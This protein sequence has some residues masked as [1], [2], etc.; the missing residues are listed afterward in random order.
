MQLF[1]DGH[2]TL[3]CMSSPLMDSV[4]QLQNNRKRVRIISKYLLFP[5]RIL[6]HITYDFGNTR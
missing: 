4:L 3:T 2:Y 1:C 6:A 5:A